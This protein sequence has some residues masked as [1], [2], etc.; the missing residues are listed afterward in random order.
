MYVCVKMSNLT[1]SNK[2][3]LGLDG[4]CARTGIYIYIY[5]DIYIYRVSKEECARLREVFLMVNYTDITQN[6]KVERL[7][8]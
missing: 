5:I 2:S 8:R 6:T 3:Q 4:V 7:Q 1:S